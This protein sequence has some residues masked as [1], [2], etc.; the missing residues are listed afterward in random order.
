MQS[1]ELE[2]TPEKERVGAVAGS[3]IM[4]GCC[5]CWW[6]LLVVVAGAG[7][8]C[9]CWLLVLVAG[10]ARSHYRVTPPILK[11]LPLYIR[12]FPLFWHCVFYE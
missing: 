7:A 10:A 8:G 12:R 3:Y 9:W 4:L 1:A 5:G 2:L 11:N 6:W